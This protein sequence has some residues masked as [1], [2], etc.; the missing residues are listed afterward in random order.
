MKK[1]LL[2]V[3]NP[4]AG[5]GAVKSQLLGIIDLFTKYGYTVTVHPTQ[6][7]SDATQIVQKEAKNYHMIVCCGG[8]G[9][10]NET[11]SGLMD[12]EKRP[13]LGYLPAGTVNDFASSLHIPKN[14]LKAAQTAMDGVVFHCD[15]GSFNQEYFTYVAAFGAFTDVAY[16]TPQSFKNVLGRLA[17]FLEGIK[18]LPQLKSYRLR[19]ETETCVIEDDFLF[20]MAANSTSIGGFQGMNLRD[21]SMDDGLFEV[22]LIKMP[23]NLAQL[24]TL[25][26]YL[27][28]LE[29]KSDFV[30]SLKA[31]RIHITS[32]EEVPWTLDGEFGG[33]FNQVTI[34]NKHKAVP[35][36]VGKF[37]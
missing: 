36:V 9:T 17:Y 32:Q 26:H 19:V 28:G 1:K 8:D 23:E 5:K 29:K 3:V 10:L 12:C 33:R 25:V 37:K 11:V 27:I 13:A 31:S 2:F 18:H 30:R 24:Q 6:K 20:G 4:M 7:K 22:S 15:V 14:M 34:E 16:D 35:I 21:V